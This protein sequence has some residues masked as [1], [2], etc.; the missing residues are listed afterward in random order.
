MTATTIYMDDPAITG[1]KPKEEVAPTTP[2]GDAPAT[3]DS[4]TVDPSQEAPTE[5]EGDEK[6]ELEE[7]QAEIKNLTGEVKKAND[8]QSQ[9]DRKSRKLEGDIKRLKKGNAKPAASGD[10]EEE[11]GEAAPAED[12]DVEE[13]RNADTK[14]SRLLLDPKY[15]PLMDKDPSLLQS[16]IRQPLLYVDDFIDAEDALDQ[17]RDMLDERLSQLPPAEKPAE[18]KKDEEEKDTPAFSAGSPN[19]RGGASGPK[20]AD[21]HR[22]EGNTDA[23][24]ETSI[25][26]KMGV[27][28]KK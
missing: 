22:A 11:G 13:R 5:G 25:F 1:D 21:Q 12:S 20:T 10:E 3:T 23:A 26:D 27:P 28:R 15:R 17:T 7:A 4:E 18:E 6:K 24:V 14:V 9:A 8:L 16:L 19:V 2:E